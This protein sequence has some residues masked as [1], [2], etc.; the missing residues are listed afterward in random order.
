MNS[1][2]I[3]EDERSL[4]RDMADCLT[5]MGY[6]VTGTIATAEECFESVRQRRPDLVLMDIHIEGGLGGIETARRL[7]DDFDIPVVFLSAHADEKTVG[8]AKLASPLGYLLKPFSMSE[9]E[10][11]VEVGLFK[12]QME[13]RLRERERWFSTTLR[14]IG[15]AVVTVDIEG[16]VTFMNRAAEDMIGRSLA[17]AIGQPHGQRF[18]PGERE[19]ALARVRSGAPRDRAAK[20]RLVATTH[21]ARRG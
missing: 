10:N 17:D 3:V 4:A 16:R 14:A 20:R 7:R 18:P 5:G 21:R 6:A 12:H 15:D 13:R 9:L 11:A 2:M 19:D 1:V 8:R